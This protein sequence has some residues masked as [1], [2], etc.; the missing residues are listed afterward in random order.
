M[1]GLKIFL[2]VGNTPVEIL[3]LINYFF[4][5]KHTSHRIFLR[6]EKFS[7]INDGFFCP[8]TIKVLTDSQISTVTCLHGGL[9]EGGG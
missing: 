4:D 7:F 6:A 5:A 8:S 9:S 3:L 1:G 2:V